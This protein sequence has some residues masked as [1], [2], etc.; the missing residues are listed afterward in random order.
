MYAALGWR[1]GCGWRDG[2]IFQTVFHGLKQI[3]E[4][5][6]EDKDERNGIIRGKTY[7]SIIASINAFMRRSVKRFRQWNYRNRPSHQCS[8]IFPCCTRWVSVFQ[9]EM[10]QKKLL[11]GGYLYSLQAD[12]QTNSS[13]IMPK[14]HDLPII[15]RISICWSETSRTNKVL[16]LARRAPL[17][18]FNPASGKSFSSLASWTFIELIAARYI[19]EFHKSKQ[20][21]RS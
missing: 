14:N 19:L 20:P 10:K 15:W 4:S 17:R 12:R 16:E 5:Q 9:S 21:S 1:D 3:K 8:G 6:M 13:I 2:S 18:S 7:K 11:V